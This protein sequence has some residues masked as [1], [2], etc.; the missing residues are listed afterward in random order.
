MIFGASTRRRYL[1]PYAAI[2]PSVLKTGSTPGDVTLPMFREDL[3]SFAKLVSAKVAGLPMRVGVN[4]QKALAGP[5]VTLAHAS[6]S[7]GHIPG[8]KH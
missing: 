3:E 5:W 8:L 7:H 6:D 4:D 2:G 1:A